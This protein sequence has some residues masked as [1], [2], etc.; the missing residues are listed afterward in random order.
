MIQIGKFCFEKDY[1]WFLG[2]SFMQTFGPIPGRNDFKIGLCQIYLQNVGQLWIA[3]D[4]Q[5]PA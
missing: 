3:I 2:V 1:V 4:V 5:Y